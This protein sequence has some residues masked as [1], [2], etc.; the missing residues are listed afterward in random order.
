M[1]IGLSPDAFNR[2]A[3]IFADPVLKFGVD[4]AW[5]EANRAHI[6]AA[7][8]DAYWNT[9]RYALP[10]INFNLKEVY[11]RLRGEFEEPIP[12]S[13]MERMAL[14][15]MM[16]GS[17]A[18]DSMP[19][20]IRE[21]FTNA[22][23]YLEA[24]AEAKKHDLSLY[25]FEHSPQRKLLNLYQG[26]QYSW[27]G[28]A[29]DAELRAETLKLEQLYLR[30]FVVSQEQFHFLSETLRIARQGGAQVIVFW[31]RVNPYLR[32]A[33]RKEPRVQV[34]WQ[35]VV[36]LS[37][38]AGAQAINLNEDGRLSCDAFYDASHMSATCFP[39]LAG[40]LLGEFP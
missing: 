12:P 23:A 37:K 19:E 29:S 8:F 17:R 16:T 24:M 28:A 9:R 14:I 13:L 20:S 15:G 6:P 22:G 4:A 31:P 18:G 1:L 2:N 25:S 32:A 27:I 5:I 40:T 3:F 30:N 11:L 39:E 26:A 38:A 34:I 36:E 21:T 7:D 35:R 33:Y 10:G